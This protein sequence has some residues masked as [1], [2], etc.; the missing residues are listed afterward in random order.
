MCN[1]FP[2]TMSLLENAVDTMINVFCQYSNLKPPADKLSKGELKQ[3]MEKE[4]A[5]FL[6]NQVNP[7]AIEELFNQLDQNQ[8]Q[9][10]S[11]EEYMV[12]IS[13]ATSATHQNLHSQ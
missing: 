7:Q 1:R 13:R 10:L 3:L 6:K 11:F 4:L 8:E 2:G 5:G 12:L 9:Q